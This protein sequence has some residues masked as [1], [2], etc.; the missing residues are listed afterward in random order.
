V[1]YRWE[2]AKNGGVVSREEEKQEKQ[3][4]HAF[5]YF[6]NDKVIEPSDCLLLRTLLLGGVAGAAAWCSDCG[7]GC[8]AVGSIYSLTV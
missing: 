2:R 6:R 7:A 5:G 8:A 3:H 4:S 1:V